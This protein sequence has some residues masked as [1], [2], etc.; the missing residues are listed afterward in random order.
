MKAMLSTRYG[1]PEVLQL[2]EVARPTP[3]GQEVLMHVHAA[4]VA[5]RTA[6]F[7]RGSHL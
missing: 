5:L 7:G 1:A 6:A 2:Q 3:R 4:S